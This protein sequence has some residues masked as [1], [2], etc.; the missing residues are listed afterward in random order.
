MLREGDWRPLNPGYNFL[1][2]ME[3]EERE[4]DDFNLDEPDF[5]DLEDPDATD[6]GDNTCKELHWHHCSCYYSQ[7]FQV[8]RGVFITVH[9]Y[10]KELLQ[11]FFS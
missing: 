2:M 7:L 6:M 11:L 9:L 3:E 5:G 4:R 1:K 8:A 10:D